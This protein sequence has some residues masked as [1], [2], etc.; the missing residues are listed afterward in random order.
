MVCKHMI[1]QQT[2]LKDHGKECRIDGALLE[3]IIQYWK[4][5]H[6]LSKEGLEFFSPFESQYGSLNLRRFAWEQQDVLLHAPDLFVVEEDVSEYLE[7]PESIE[8]KHHAKILSGEIRGHKALLLMR[9]WPDTK[10]AVSVW[11]CEAE[12][13]YFDKGSATPLKG[14]TKEINQKLQE[15]AERSVYDAG[16]SMTRSGIYPPNQDLIKY[17]KSLPPKTIRRV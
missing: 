6:D 10:I 12:V 5:H 15:L 17:V 14:D 7:R 4:K 9:T 11:N 3:R 2:T 13:I 1:N 8:A 16:G